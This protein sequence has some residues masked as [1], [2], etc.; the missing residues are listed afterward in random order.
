MPKVANSSIGKCRCR[1]RGC[2]EAAHIRQVKGHARGALYL[3]CP[4][5]GRDL[6]L[7]AGPLAELQ[8]WIVEHAIPEG[9][10]P[11]QAEG[12][13]Q[14]QAGA[15]TGPAPREE[16]KPAAAGDGLEGGKKKPGFLSRFF[17]DADKQLNEYLEG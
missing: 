14:G 1:I 5:H 6:P 7:G 8:E 4:T 16:Q 12:Q 11:G 10:E 3:N 2:T 9:Q 13:Q 17:R 15:S